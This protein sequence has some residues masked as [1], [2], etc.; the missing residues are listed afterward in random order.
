MRT[1][2]VSVVFEDD[3]TREVMEIASI[4]E[5][6]KESA[7]ML[8]R[9]LNKELKLCGGLRWGVGIVRGKFYVEDPSSLYNELD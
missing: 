2:D 4:P 6:F 9:G 1:H 8:C 7:E 5:E 3:K